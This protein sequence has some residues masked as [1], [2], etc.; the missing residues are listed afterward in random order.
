MLKVALNTI[1]PNLSHWHISGGYYTNWSWDDKG[2]LTI[3][4][5]EITGKNIENCTRNPC[6]ILNVTL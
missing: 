3:H 2:A 1:N 4:V 5:G 6:L